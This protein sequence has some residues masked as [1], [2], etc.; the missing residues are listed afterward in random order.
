[1]GVAM[2]RARLS[3]GKNKRKVSR[4]SVDKIKSEINRIL[5]K[6]SS[7]RFPE[8]QMLRVVVRSDKA[9][10]LDFLRGFTEWRA[11]GTWQDYPNEH[12]T[13]IEVQ[14]RED[15]DEL[16]GKRLVGLFEKLNKAVI[17]EEK[18]YVSTYPIEVTSI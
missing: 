16:N 10:H 13:V 18:L 12:N 14:Y 9:H 3:R 11:I 8:H 6:S 4:L 1:M 7:S 2:R 15:A 17:G 5:F